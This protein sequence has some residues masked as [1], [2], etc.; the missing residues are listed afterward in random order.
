MNKKSIFLALAI[1]VAS[2]AQAQTNFLPGYFINKQNEKVECLIKNTDSRFAPKSIEYK[3]D[4]EAETK[5]ISTDSLATIEI[6]DKWKYERFTTKIDVSKEKSI[7]LSRK[8]EPEFEERNL[9]LKVLNEG[10]INLYAFEDGWLNLFFVKDKNNAIEQLLYKEYMDEQ[11]ILR[12]NQ[13]YKSQLSNYLKNGS[14]SNSDIANCNYNKK[15]LMTLIEKHNQHNGNVN[16][17]FEKVEKAITSISLKAGTNLIS[18]GV[19]EASAKEYLTDFGTKLNLRAGIEIEYLLPY[20]NYKWAF[21]TDPAFS[22]YEAQNQ[23]NVSFISDGIV[24]SAIKYN[25]I[26]LPLG[27][28]YYHKLKNDARLYA[29]A[30]YVI[31]FSSNSTLEYSRSNDA[32][33]KQISI[34]PRW[35]MYLAMGYKFNDK[36][37]V[38]MRVYNNQLIIYRYSTWDIKYQVASLQLSYKLF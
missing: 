32:L 27:I 37:G 30:S 4:T 2:F 33:L 1:S 38:E 8:K 13:L 12:K 6:F 19:S 9:L 3:L 17:V 24:K 11:R 16:I 29:T 28:R 26:E 7:E 23:E 34:R 21:V 36:M 22:I 35:N 14:V 10:A 31:N 25:A 15:E 18:A 5:K 20:N